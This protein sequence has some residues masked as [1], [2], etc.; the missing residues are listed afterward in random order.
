MKVKIKKLHPD[1]VVPVCENWR[2]RHGPD[3]SMK[4]QE[5]EIVTYGTGL[6]SRFH[7][8]TSV[9][10]FRGHQFIKLECPYQCSWRD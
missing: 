7:H 8:G 6:Q 1:A 3:S 4:N 10:F 2:C 9:C 5:M